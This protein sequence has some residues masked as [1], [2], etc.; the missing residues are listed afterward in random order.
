[1]HEGKRKVVK[2]MRTLPTGQ[3]VVLINGEQKIIDPKK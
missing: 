1:M 2:L 3:R